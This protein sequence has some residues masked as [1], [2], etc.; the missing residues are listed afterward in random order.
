MRNKLLEAIKPLQLNTNDKNKLVNTI[1]DISNSGGGGEGN[2]EYEYY[3]ITDDESI[4]AELGI[5]GEMKLIILGQI[6]MFVEKVLYNVKV[7]NS[8]C[9]VEMTPYQ[10]YTLS[11]KYFG[12]FDSRNYI[13]VKKGNIYYNNIIFT[14]SDYLKLVG[15]MILEENDFANNMNVL[16]NQIGF[17]NTIRLLTPISKEEYESLIGKIVE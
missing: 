6:F 14:D 9:Y 10:N 4:W 11:N 17:N 2:I 15:E 16:F 12:T 1:I 7:D 5:E 13:K 8:Y 3:K